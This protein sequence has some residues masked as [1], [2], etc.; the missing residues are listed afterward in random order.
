MVSPSALFAPAAPKFIAQESQPPSAEQLELHEGLVARHA[1][2]D[3][4][5]LY[6]ALGSALFTAI[7]QLPEY[8]PTRCESEIFQRHGAD[9]ARH[10]DR[11]SR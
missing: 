10:V 8:Y 3:P 1:H 7:T 4:K 9:I 6:D 5:F 11:C 2:I